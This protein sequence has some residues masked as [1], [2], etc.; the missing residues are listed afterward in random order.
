MKN[1]K[2]KTALLLI[3]TISMVTSVFAQGPPPGGRRG[4][5]NAEEMVKREKQN[6]Y[7]VIEDLSDDQKMLLDGIYD[8]FIVSFNE[9]RE[10]V[11][12]SR[13]FQAM[14]PKM[15]ALRDEK[16]ELI[17]DVLSEDQFK[18]YEGLM[19]KQRSQRRENMERNGGG[20]RNAP[21][22]DTLPKQDSTNSIN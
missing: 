4:G 19:E 2:F 14:R 21:E 11:M 17:A 20:R 7:K 1:L 22:N 18:L 12:Q 15:I 5:F 8:E 16:D 6:V 3:L 9:L 13:D 10:E